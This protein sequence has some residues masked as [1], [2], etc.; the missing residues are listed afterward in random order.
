VLV[1]ND[2]RGRIR[3]QTDGQLKTGRDV[4]IA[5]LLGAE[6][7]GFSSAPLVAMGCIMMR[8][9]HLN[10]CPVGIATQDP[11]LRAKFAGKPEFVET[12]FRFIAEEVREIMAALGFRT[13]DE[14]IGRADRLDIRHAVEHWKAKGLDLTPLLHRP[15]VGPEVAIRK[16]VEQDHGLERSLDM[17]TLVPMCRPALERG[18]PV[19]VRLPI[20]NVNRTVGTILGYEV[21]SRHG[22]A[23]LPD[24]TVRLHF[25]GSAG[26]SFGAFV[27]KGITLTLEGDANDYLGKGLSGGKIIAYPPREATFVPE[28]NILVGNVVLY[29]ATGGEAYF[30]GVAGERFAVRNSGAATVVEGVGD[31]G[32]EYMTGGRVVVI[33][34]TGR[35]FAAG[36]S[37]GVAYVLDEA[38]DFKRRCNLGMVDL[39][40][41]VDVEDVELVKDL[42]S[43][44]I[45]YTQSAV[46][47]RLLV[48]WERARERFVKVMPKDYKRVLAAIKKAQETGMSVD[49]AVMASAHG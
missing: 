18:E 19:D 31:H 32:C 13:M 4:V 30:R 38:G 44:H 49:D 36:M 40:P 37:G 39:E 28:E 12:F 43:R 29:G 14:M 11:R 26:Q 42:L 16:I 15:A 41:L 3:V 34:R 45:R 25:S 8:V 1:K 24:D 46:A 7:F 20:R 2:L 9:C 22:A 21:T 33:G 48:N 47:A 5:A 35:N 6:E 17:T 10:T 27:P 23:G